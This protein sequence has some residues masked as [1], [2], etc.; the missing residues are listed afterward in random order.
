MKQLWA[1]M[2]ALAMNANVTYKVHAVSAVIWL[3]L[4]IPTWYLWRNSLFWIAF[5]SLYANFVS[6]WG[7]YQAALAQLV[8]GRAEVAAKAAVE[9]VR[10][11]A[12]QDTAMLKH[13]EKTVVGCDRWPDNCI[14]D[15]PNE[16]PLAV[17]SG[18]DPQGLL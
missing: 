12:M 18:D 4:V 2:Q 16:C 10:L 5:I 6:H 9:I 14:C 8:A 1:W 13:I 3:L 17:T 7:A 11:D 15:D